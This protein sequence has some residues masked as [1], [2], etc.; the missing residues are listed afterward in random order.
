M[1]RLSDRISPRA[2]RLLP[3]N[4]ASIFVSPLPDGSAEMMPKNP[5]RHELPK[6]L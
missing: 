3:R 6:R 2:V 4:R 5:K 1:Q